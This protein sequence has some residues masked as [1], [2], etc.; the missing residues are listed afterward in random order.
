MKSNRLLWLLIMMMVGLVPV[1]SQTPTT[2]GTEFWVSFM[3][4]GHREADA[5]YN[6]LTLII[7]AKEGCHGSV[8]NVTGSWTSNFNV[9]DHG[10]TIVEIPGDL[11]YNDQVDGVSDKGFLVLADDTI[12]LYIGNAAQNSYD[13]S[14]VLPVSALGT[15]YTLQTYQ[16]LTN[17][18]SSHAPKIRASFL[19]VAVED[20]TVVEI[21]PSVV[22][23]GD[24]PAGQSYRVTLNRGQCYHVMTK[25]G[26]EV[27][28]DDGDFSGTT[29]Q[30]DKP[31]AVFNG[32][33][34][35]TVPVGYTSGYDHVFEQAL[36]AESWGKRFVVTGTR[37]PSIMTIADDQVKITALDDHTTVNLNGDPFISLNAGDSRE[38]NLPQEVPNTLLESDKP[39]AVYL[40]QPSHGSGG[41]FGDPSMVWISPVEQTLEE[42]TF[43]TFEVPNVQNHYV[44]IVCYSDNV[45]SMTLDNQNISGE[46]ATVSSAPEF[47]YARYP[48]SAGAHLLS[49]PGGFVAHVYGIGN[50]I[51]YAY[52]VGSS[53]KQ[54]TKQLYVN[55]V[56]STE[57]PDGFV[58]CQRETMHFRFE[59]NYEFDHVAWY[60]GNGDTTEGQVVSYAYSR[61]NDYHLQAVVFRLMEGE[62]L[63]FDTVAMDIHVKRQYDEIVEEHTT[64][65][66][67]FHFLD[68]DYDVPGLYRIPL[69][70]VYGCD[71]I[72]MLRLNV[73]DDIPY[74]TAVTACEQFT[75]LDGVH[76]TSGRYEYKVSQP[77]GC[78]SLYILNLEIVN[79]PENAERT[80]ASCDAYPWY[81]LLCDHTDDYSWPFV[82]AEGCEYDSVL[83]FTLEP[84]PQATV[85]TTAC[86]LFEWKGQSYT[87]GGTYTITIPVENGCDSLVTLSL[88]MYYSP[89]LGEIQ[90]SQQIAMANS[91][92]PG[93][94]T[95][96]IDSTGI[97]P[98]KLH[99]ELVGNAPWRIMPHGAS[100]V[101]TATSIGEMLLRVRTENEY[102][103]DGETSLSINSFGFGVEDQEMP[104]VELFPNPSDGQLCVK[105]E[106]L[107][108]V[109]IYDMMGQQL[110]VVSSIDGSFI[111]ADVH[112]L[113]PAIYLVKIQTRKGNKLLLFSVL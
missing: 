38:F 43:S 61:P 11:A 29:I 25:N 99:W 110:R 14:N 36:P 77:D 71:S 37:I 32:N 54:L 107:V 86:D 108:D 18:A 24:H 106:E 2:Q 112:D 52:S 47:S 4:N 5:S 68:R 42:V 87:V 82:T 74:D 81:G 19:V 48:I 35:T 56:L 90:G 40:Y 27:Y 10:V 51:G 104:A 34:M 30:S 39:I 6:H 89:E 92:W 12:S 58:V 59:S 84:I 103:C 16:S 41:Q 78:D 28:N 83:H 57:Y 60:F 113:K 17:T 111:R 91:F 50:Q 95:Y 80:W 33:C 45:A 102:G 9:S 55:D 3:R 105:G 21:T 20:A 1:Y 23:A 53:A 109:V 93:T 63:P 22:T 7:S 76:D 49:C 31:V 85:D 75:W 13:A 96:Y 100:C 65:A 46:F 73:G 26:G 101:V 69:S 66:P 15:Q 94:Y 98:D 44:N 88:T 67:T 8:S 64:C 62:V 79:P 72:I 97:D 70:T